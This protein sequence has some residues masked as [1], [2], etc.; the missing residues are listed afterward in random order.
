MQVYTNVNEI[1][2][3]HVLM[4]TQKRYLQTID[5]VATTSPSPPCPTLAQ[6]SQDHKFDNSNL[7]PSL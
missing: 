5:K 2:Q 3:A 7:L 1:G 4:R 6:S